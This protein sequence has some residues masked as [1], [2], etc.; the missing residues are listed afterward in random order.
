MNKSYGA[1]FVEYGVCFN[2]GIPFWPKIALLKIL[3]RK[4]HCDDQYLVDDLFCF[5]M[6]CFVCVFIFDLKSGAINIPCF[7]AEADEHGFN[8]SF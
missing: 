2:N 3:C 6:F 1:K 4:M 5:A 7:N 8:F